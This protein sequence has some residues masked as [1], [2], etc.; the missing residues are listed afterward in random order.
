MRIDR[1]MEQ[2]STLT[3]AEKLQVRRQVFEELT[4]ISLENAALL[5]Q[6]DQRMTRLAALG[7]FVTANVADFTGETAAAQ[8]ATAR[9]RIRTELATWLNAQDGISGATVA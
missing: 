9:T 8:A 1:L 7:V 3:D 5:S 4:S 6:L 2:Y